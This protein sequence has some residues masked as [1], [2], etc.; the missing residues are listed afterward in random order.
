MEKL[1][2]VLIA[3]LQDA[4]INTQP[5]LKILEY[6]YKFTSKEK[7]KKKKR[8]QTARLVSSETEDVLNCN[9]NDCRSEYHQERVQDIHKEGS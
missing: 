9:D 6:D 8:K 2:R 4:W 3:S 5:I 1:V 7:K